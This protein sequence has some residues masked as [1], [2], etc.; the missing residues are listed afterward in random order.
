MRFKLHG[1]DIS[2]HQTDGFVKAYDDADFIVAKA[3]EGRTWTDSKYSQFAKDA[4]DMNI[5]FGAYH[6]ARPDYAKN[7]P[8][9]EA[10]NFVQK[11]VS[12]NVDNLSFMALDVEAGALKVQGLAEWCKQWIEKV[13]R[14]IPGIPVY[15]YIQASAYNLV[16][17]VPNCDGFWIAH[18]DNSLSTKQTHQKY[19]IPEDKIV[20]KQYTSNVG[21]LD[22][23]IMYIDED[24]LYEQVA[25][26][27]QKMSWNK[28]RIAEINRTL[29]ACT[30]LIDNEFVNV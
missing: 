30:E 10:N 25:K 22:E 19:K 28:A 11:V 26:D 13:K 6:F 20:M 23:D 15:I 16:E 27:S 12:N 29:K 24:K 9:D 3:T 4:A 8:V 7:L 5:M 14:Q 17:T 18:Y 1:Y 21:T 2:H